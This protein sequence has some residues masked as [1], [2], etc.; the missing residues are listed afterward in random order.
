MWHLASRIQVT[1]GRWRRAGGGGLPAGVV[2]AGFAS[3]ATFVAGLAAVNLLSDTNRGVYGVFFAAFV[4]GT[5][6]PHNLI[7]L[8]YQVYSVGRPLDERLRYIGHATAS[9]RR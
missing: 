4:V 3:L 6:F 5:T 2:D 8:P 1:L 9:G 7:F